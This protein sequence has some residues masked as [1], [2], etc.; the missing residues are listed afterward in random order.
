[1]KLASNQRRGPE[2]R[3]TLVEERSFTSLCI[4]PTVFPIP[5]TWLLGI[6]SQREQN[7]LSKVA[8]FLTLADR[9]VIVN[10]FSC[11]LMSLRYVSRICMRSVQGV[12]DRSSSS[13][14]A[15]MSRSAR[16]SQAKP[17]SEPSTGS[18]QQVRWVSC[19]GDS[20]EKAGEAAEESRRLHEA[21]KAEKVMHLICW[22]PHLL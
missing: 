2:R 21:E 7:H 1:M 5:G 16:P 10:L 20:A 8:P 3:H 11:Q 13:S 14:M 4:A 22:G 9:I 17:S 6:N 15:M 12:K 18:T 19:S